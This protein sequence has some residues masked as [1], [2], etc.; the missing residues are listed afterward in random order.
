MPGV[1]READGV[2]RNVSDAVGV[3]VLGACAAWAMITAAAR[4]G[5]PEGMLLAV[6]AVTAGHAAGRIFGA[7]APVVAPCAGALAGLALVLTVPDLAPGPA[8]LS[9][10]GHAGATAALL[11]L[12]T[13]A[14]CCAAWAAAPAARPALRV[15]AAGITVTAGALGSVAGVV[16]CAAV[17]LGSLAAGRMRRRGLGVTGLAVA[18]V[19]IAGGTWAVAG[20]ALPRGLAAAAEDQ[21][22]PQRVALWH[23]ALRMAREEPALGVGPGRFGTAGTLTAQPLPQETTPH[24]APLQLAA[25]Q[26]VIGAALLVAVFGWVLYALWRSRRP[27][28][29]VLTAGAALTAVAALASVGNALSFTAVSVGAGLLTGLATARPLHEEAPECTLPSRARDDRLTA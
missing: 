16:A 4:D 7:L 13:G 14:A 23:D 19:L 12:S 8:V 2:R 15:L 27:T 10:L 1:G 9:P 5:R 17:L 29:V 18:A 28:P 20:N 25:E 24:S 21:L 3:G 26:G 6:L 11:T 22:T